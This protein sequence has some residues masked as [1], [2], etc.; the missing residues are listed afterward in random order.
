[1]GPE[2]ALQ[3]DLVEGHNMLLFKSKD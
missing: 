3:H 1:M 2:I